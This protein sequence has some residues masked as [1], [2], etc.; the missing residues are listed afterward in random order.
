M[1]IAS[2]FQKLPDIVVYRDHERVIQWVN[3]A[4]IE[5]FGYNAEHWVGQ[6][7]DGAVSGA[8][9]GAFNE[10]RAYGHILIDGK[11]H[12]VEWNEAELPAGGSLA[13]GRVNLDRRKTQRAQVDKSRDRR[14][15][16]TDVYGRE[17]PAVPATLNQ[18][19][20]SGQDTKKQFTAPDAKAAQHILLAEDDLLNA[21][22]A[23]TL[24]ERT[25]CIVTHVQDG[26]EA[27]AAAKERDFDL[28]FMDIR[29]PFMDGLSAT[30][31]IR[32]LG[33]KWER[34]P[35][36]ALTANAFAEDKK[37]CHR[38]GMN[39]FLTKPISID[40]LYAAKKRW[41]NQQTQVKTA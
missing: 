37:S 4:F 34:T 11:M 13:V 7:L 8:Q 17:K 18:N 1:D 31:A 23:R 21:K 2:L 35:I 38:A 12:W 19:T 9:I 5:A 10:N 6:K 25:G 26:K 22:L 33:G 16:N 28:V 15:N 32:A 20:K 36:V 27:L 39:G 41:T 29:M 30:R 3:E 40:A 14:R 24:L